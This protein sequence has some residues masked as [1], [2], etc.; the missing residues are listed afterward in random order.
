MADAAMSPFMPFKY[1]LAARS[2]MDSF[3]M[4]SSEMVARILSN[5]REVRLDLN[6]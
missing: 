5:A 6:S 2:S 4:N 3:L 1:D